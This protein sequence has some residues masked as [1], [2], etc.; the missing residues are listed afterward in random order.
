MFG[1]K[2]LETIFFFQFMDCLKFGYMSCLAVE[3]GNEKKNSVCG[4]FEYWLCFMFG[5]KKSEQEI[6]FF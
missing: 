1:G 6:F 2:E 3:I 5:W 4:L